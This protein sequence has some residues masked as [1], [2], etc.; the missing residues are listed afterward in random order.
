MDDFKYLADLLHLFAFFILIW[1]MLKRQNC[2]GISYRTQE[3][4]LIVFVVRYLDI[5]V[6]PQRLW[7]VVLKLTFIGATALC[8][9]LIKYQNPISVSYDAIMDTFPSRTVLIPFCFIVGMFLPIPFE[10][11]NWYLRLNNFTLVLEALAFLP[12]LK[13]LRKI[14][15]IEIITGSYI[16]CLGIYRFVY[17]C[18]WIWRLS[19]G[20][21]T[22]HH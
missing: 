19:L 2:R 11:A 8:L 16:A 18:S 5:F 9:Y 4:F 3:L 12:Q 13:I 17:L 1:N 21:D 10:Y 14:N 20:E 15:E 6:F 22:M 7:N